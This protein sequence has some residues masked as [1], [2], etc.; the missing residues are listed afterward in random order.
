MLHARAPRS[1]AHRSARRMTCLCLFASA[2]GL[3]DRPAQAQP[4]AG[5]PTAAEVPAPNSAP[6]DTPTDT[7]VPPGESASTPEAPLP[8][9]AD[10]PVEDT[11]TANAA[12]PEETKLAEGGVLEEF[13]KT[14]TIGVGARTGL[15]F[16]LSGPVE[17]QLR[18]D[19]GLVDQ[20]N[21]RPFMAGNFTPN[22]GFFTQLELGTANGLGNFA[23]LDA[24]GQVK[25]MDELQ[26]W[27]G[28]HIPANDR[29][30]MNGPFF[31]NTW[32]FAIAVPSYPFDVGA[33]DRGATLWGLV[34]GGRLKYHASI[35]DL[36]PGRDIGQA[37]YGGRLTVHLLEPEDFYY[38]SGTYFGT[39]DVLAIGAVVQGQKG[40]DGANN[41]FLGFSFD[42][43]FE[44]N[45]DAAGTFTVEAGYWNFE[46]TGAGYVVNQNTIDTGLGVAGPFPGQ[47]GMGVLS[48]LT[49]GKVG[50]GQI[51]PNVR[52]Q[53]GEYAA[54]KSVVFDGGLAYVIDGFNHKYHVNFRHQE[55]GPD[56][57]TVSS[58]MIQVGAQYM[59]SR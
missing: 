49:P 26:L 19:D 5:E 11:P 7:G 44:K 6:P 43:M 22:L 45:M 52:L 32:N 20:M 47:A 29:N 18:L 17:G 23:I 4:D 1:P 31:T 27:V 14:F 12:G 56:G 37:R 25:F 24:I 2:Y 34:A 54:A 13:A 51:Q 42:A 57:A 48:W 36:Q 50:I 3:W 10:P 21:I 16:G 41:D 15:N 35:V 33:R 59:M 53:Y 55:V 9:A 39:K 58:D 30:N 8:I 38:N 28:Q 40:T 46:N